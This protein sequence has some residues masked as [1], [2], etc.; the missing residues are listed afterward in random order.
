MPMFILFET[1]GVLMEGA[2]SL[3][4]SLDEPQITTLEISCCRFLNQNNCFQFLN[5]FLSHLKL[6]MKFYFK[7]GNG[8]GSK[9]NEKIF[10]HNSKW[11]K[12]NEI[13]LNK[14]LTSYHQWPF[15]LCNEFHSSNMAK[16][17]VESKM[18]KIR[19]L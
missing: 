19:G 10:K 9:G 5:M 8:N 6:F 16:Y 15:E 14:Y 11:S 4:E 7:K 18:S 1:V 12:Q 2:F 17:N 13:I 3:W